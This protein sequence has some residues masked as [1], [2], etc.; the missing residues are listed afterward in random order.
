MPTALVTGPLGQDGQ[1]LTPILKEQ[2]Y[3]V[4]GVSKPG[5]QVQ[6]EVADG[7]T[8]HVAADLCQPS[9]V[10][11]LLEEH[12]PEAIYHLAAAHHSSQDL[13]AADDI[14][15]K[16]RMLRVNFDAVRT[17]AFTM[18]QMRSDAHL[19]FAASSQMYTARSEQRHISEATPRDPA[20]FYG[21]T[22]A[23]SVDL[24]GALRTATGLRASSAIL[25]NHESA[26]RSPRFVSR[27]L[28]Q[29]AAQAKAG[30]KPRVKLMNIGAL[31]DWSC[32][33]DVVSAL[34]LMARAATPQDYVVASGRL[35]SVRELADVA[36]RHVGLDWRDHVSFDMDAPTP[37]LI[38]NSQRISENLV[39]RP[40]SSFESMIKMMVDHDM[41]ALAAG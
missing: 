20:T 29:A 37:A 5:Q 12:R 31:V 39:W 7:L 10:A 35:H 34:W 40:K 1:L 32:A 36:F 4:V 22:K 18:L 11:S 3:C 16:Q 23:W 15:L 2:G 30:M 13:A 27:K 24:L 17:I 33:R 14:A 25:F 41:S 21:F 6:C 9:V 28:T 8:L 26:L 38:G 19:V